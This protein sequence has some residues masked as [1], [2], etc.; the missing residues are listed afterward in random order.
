MSGWTG[1][2]TEQATALPRCFTTMSNQRTQLPPYYRVMRCYSI[3]KTALKQR[4]REAMRAL[5]RASRDALR[6]GADPDADTPPVRSREAA[7]EWGFD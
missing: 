4:S 5:E 3:D 1:A 6:H 7:D 2:G